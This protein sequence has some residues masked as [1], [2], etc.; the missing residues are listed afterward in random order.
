[1]QITQRHQLPNAHVTQNDASGINTPLLLLKSRAAG[2]V[3]SVSTYAK[4]VAPALLSAAIWA[5]LLVGGLFSVVLLAGVL[6]LLFK[7]P[8][9]LSGKQ[10]ADSWA[11][12]ASYGERIWLN[13]LLIPIPADVNQKIT[14][15]YLV[16]WTGTLIAMLGAVSSSLLLTATGLL[17]AYAAQAVCLGKLIG[18]YNEMKDKAPLYRFWTEKPVNDNKLIRKRKP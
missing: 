15:L 16:F 10:Q 4:I 6:L 3:G 13:R 17:V 12:R 8:S 11:R 18:L 7:L 5:K 2:P 9:L 14:I 1:M